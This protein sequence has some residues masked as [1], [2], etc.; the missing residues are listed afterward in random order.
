[1]LPQWY[2]IVTMKKNKIH[3]T[4]SIKGVIG[5]IL[6]AAGFVLLFIYR[7]SQDFSRWY[8]TRVYQIWVNITGRIMNVFPFSVSEVSLYILIGII[9]VTGLRMFWR[10]VGRKSG[11]QEVCSGLLSFFLLAAVLFFLY[12][13]NCGI[14]YNRE[15]FTESSGIVIEDYTADELTEVCQWLTGEVNRLAEVVERDEEG[16]MQLAG[17]AAEGAVEA[18]EELGEEYPELAGYY[19][20]PKALLIP[21]VLSIQ[22]LSGIYSPFTIEA[23]YNSGMVDYNIPFTACH[24]LSHLRGFMQE[25]EANFIAFLACSKSEDM[26]FQYSGYLSGWTYCMNVLYNV[27][28]DV[29][30]KVREELTEAVE[31]DLK[32]NREYWASYDGTVAEVANQIND[33]YL[34]A[35]GQADGVKSYNQMVDLIITYYHNF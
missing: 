3:L 9:L 25:E 5:C 28:Y 1:M 4:N 18:M 10:L 30:E 12:V 27:D 23:N 17:S 16:V 2:T 8:S 7:L 34:K 6:V 21:W 31:P 15:S 14:N 24:E 20:R 13:I 29:W 33:T 32:A 11:K 35:N 22:H 26:E 19:P